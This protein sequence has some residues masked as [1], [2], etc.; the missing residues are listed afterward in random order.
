MN[1]SNLWW[2]PGW[3]NRHKTLYDIISYNDVTSTLSSYECGRNTFYWSIDFEKFFSIKYIVA[4][5]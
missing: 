5:L 4:K 2:K 1:D 3:K